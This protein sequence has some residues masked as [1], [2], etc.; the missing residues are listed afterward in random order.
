VI[1]STLSAVSAPT[2]HSWQD[3]QELVA[4]GER[5]RECVAVIMTAKWNAGYYHGRTFSWRHSHG[6]GHGQSFHVMLFPHCVL[7]YYEVFIQEKGTS[8]ERTKK[9]Y[10]SK[11]SNSGSFRTSRSE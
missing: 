9:D 10:E 8:Q 4:L 5:Q 3:S 6:H 11:T 7:K 1:V 2:F